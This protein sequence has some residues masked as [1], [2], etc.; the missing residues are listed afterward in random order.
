MRKIGAI[1][2]TGLI[3]G[4]VQASEPFPAALPVV[5]ARSAGF[6]FWGVALS[7]DPAAIFW[8]PAALGVGE[9][10]AADLTVAAGGFEGPS[11]WTFLLANCPPN[12][13]ERYGLGLIRRSTARDTT[14]LK[15]FQVIVPL[16]THSLG[17]ILPPVGMSLKFISE[18]HARRDWNYGAGLDLGVVYRWR[19]WTGGWTLHNVAASNLKAFR[20]ESWAGAS[21]DARWMV[22]GA[23]VELVKNLS[24]KTLS[25]RF[26][27]GCELVVSQT[28]PVV[29][30]GTVHDGAVRWITLGVGYRYRESNARIEYA[31]AVESG[32]SRHRIHT[33]TYGFGVG[34]ATSRGAPSGI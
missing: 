4:V 1:A 13:G 19:G 29:R 28:L 27:G 8:N 21:W 7:S 33:L 2:A 31:V 10:L 32:G 25:R 11:N 9:L 6:G 3:C 18:S 15:S 34:A 20:R 17:Q 12:D 30:A 24:R 14:T 26:H 16:S 23:Q 5:T 22:L